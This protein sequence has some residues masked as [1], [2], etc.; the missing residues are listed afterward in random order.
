[1][2][3]LY[4]TTGVGFGYGRLEPRVE[5]FLGNIG[6]PNHPAYAVTISSQAHDV[7]ICLHL[8]LQPWMRP[9]ITH[10]V[11]P[12]SVTPVN[13]L[14][15]YRFGSRAPHLLPTPKGGV[16]RRFGRLA[17]PGSVWAVLRR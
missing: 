14:T 6:T 11:L 8:T 5:E 13:S 4:L 17:S 16:H 15:F 12:F 10:T 1:L 7:R 9:G 2:G 3:N